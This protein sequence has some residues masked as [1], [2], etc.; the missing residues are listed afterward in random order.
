MEEF[1]KVWLTFFFHCFPF[2]SADPTK[3]TSKVFF[4]VEI[5]GGEGGRIVLGLFGDT[6]MYLWFLSTSYLSADHSFSQSPRQLRTSVLFA[7]EKKVLA[8]LA[9]PFIS[10]V[11]FSIESV[12][13][14]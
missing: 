10:R 1:A 3:I 5:E 9:S 14:G 2:C 4:D 13:E 7:L 8:S 6:G 12:S 11:P